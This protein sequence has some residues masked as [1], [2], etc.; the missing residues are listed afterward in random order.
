[1][2]FRVG[3]HHGHRR[4]EPVAAAS[5]GLRL[6]VG[7]I[8]RDA[9]AAAV[10]LPRDDAAEDVRHPRRHAPAEVGLQRMPQARAVHMHHLAPPDRHPAHE[11]QRGVE[12]IVHHQVRI[13]EPRA[14]P[15]DVAQHAL[16]T[17]HVVRHVAVGFAAQ[18]VLL[19]VELHRVMAREHRRLDAEAG[20][21]ARAF[22]GGG[23]HL[24]VRA[25]GA[26]RMGE[27]LRA[28]QVAARVRGREVDD[29]RRHRRTQA[30]TGRARP[31]R[32][33]KATPARYMPSAPV[34]PKPR[35]VSR[36]SRISCASR[37]SSCGATQRCSV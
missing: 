17:E 31:G 15:K 26:Q 21:K 19:A 34:M 9:R 6:A 3:A 22:V 2:R 11:Q 16:R 28:H 10:D 18:H 24:H 25:G 32:R 4:G 13:A 37:A 35:S 30:A 23:E 36:T 8:V 20:K 29:A 5:V 1:M 27:Q 14:Q 7:E 12:G 33:R